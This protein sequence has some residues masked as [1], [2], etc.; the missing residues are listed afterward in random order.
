MPEFERVVTFEMD[1][2][3]LEA[4]V[5]Q[6]SASDEPPSDVPA[7]RITVLADR[8]AGRVVVS[9]R[10]ASEDDLKRGSAALEGM[11]PPDVG[12]VRRVSVDV[13]EVALERTAS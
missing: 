11:S 9:T 13:Y 2:A 3:T 7:T 6:I 5:A 8:D 4:L 12:N 1:D 10:Y